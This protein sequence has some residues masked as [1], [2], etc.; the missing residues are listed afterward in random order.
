MEYREIKENCFGYDKQHQKCKA[1]NGLYCKTEK[2]KFYKTVDENA[3]QKKQAE[4]NATIKK[5]FTI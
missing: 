2:C 1:L 5:Y 3:E 4:G